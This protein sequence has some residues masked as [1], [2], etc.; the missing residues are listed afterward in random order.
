MRTLTLPLSEEDIL[1]LHAGEGVLLSGTIFTARDCAHKR[2][3]A[4]L[5]RGEQI[6]RAHV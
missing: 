6:G 4:L 1:S 3:F 5:D 2:L